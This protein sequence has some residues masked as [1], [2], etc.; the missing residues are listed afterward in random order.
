MIPSEESV[1]RAG[2]SHVFMV[3]LLT[4][5]GLTNKDR[6][7]LAPR[8]SRLLAEDADA[9]VV[10]VV[11]VVVIVDLASEAIAARAVGDCMSRGCILSIL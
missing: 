9:V 10:V 8:R 1:D 5:L 11:V 2:F 4:H 7:I 3:S 6:A